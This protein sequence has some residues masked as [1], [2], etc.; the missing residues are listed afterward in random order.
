MKAEVKERVRLIAAGGL[1]KNMKQ[2]RRQAVGDNPNAFVPNAELEAHLQE[3]ELAEIAA[4]LL[5]LHDENE[6]QARYTLEVLKYI[7]SL[8]EEGAP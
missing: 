5:E 3:D 7:A 8:R 2:G 6:E 1:P 4:W